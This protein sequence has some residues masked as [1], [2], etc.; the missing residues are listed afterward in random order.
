V[1]KIR[2]NRR[3]VLDFCTQDAPNAGDPP[4]R[5]SITNTGILQSNGA[6]TIQTSTG[7]LT[8]A[9]AAGNGNI[10][11]TPNGTG[12]VIIGT[13]N[14]GRKL[15][16]TGNGITIDNGTGSALLELY[17][18]VDYRLQASD[19]FI[20]FDV[21]SAASRLEIF[22][23]GN[24]SIGGTSDAG[25]RLDVN[26]TFRQSG[27]ITAAAAIARGS[28][29]SPTLVAAANNDVLVGLDVNP[30][31][32]NGAFTG[33]QNYA[34]R[35]GTSSNVPFGLPLIF[36][37]KDQNTNVNFTISNST[38][39]TSAS[40]GINILGANGRTST[41]SEYSALHSN[42]EFASNLVI[43]PN[44]PGVKHGLV[45]SI[46]GT[47][48][49]SNLVVYTAGRAATNKKLTL[50]NS[51]GNLLLQSGGTHTDAGFRLDVNGT[52]RVQGE[53]TVGNGTDS[54]IRANSSVV[55]S[56]QTTYIQA[57]TANNS[58]M[59]Q[60]RPSGTNNSMTGFFLTDSSTT[61]SGTNIMLFGRGVVTLPN[62][63]VTYIGN[64]VSA[65]P[66][67]NSLH[68]GFL[69]SNTSLNRFEAARIWNSGNLY[70][71]KGGT[72]TDVASAILNV[73]STTQGFLPPRMTTTQ[74]NTIASPATGLVV[75]DT[76]LNKLAVYTGATWETVTSL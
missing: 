25:F 67:G 55:S 51:T 41:I 48:S 22:S 9:T 59:I 44:S 61:A 69:V 12:N 70:L 29:V 62:T 14:Y 37:G 10:V 26:G 66:S 15:N 40:A 5:W 38:S 17:S 64:I 76:T 1:A 24:V 36:I 58:T 27:S 56:F 52:A 33:V 47:V 75:Y 32:T 71:Q 19:K 31:F 4:V 65:N 11:L 46:P 42:P 8:L 45:I 3:G 54:I 39:G 23:S 20:I 68:L 30:T 28:F 21:T 72:F 57:S 18:T 50:F 2:S 73:N 74:K 63:G 16:I 34:L 60:I 53:L 35:V 6:Q 49:G 43:E 13:A 7:N